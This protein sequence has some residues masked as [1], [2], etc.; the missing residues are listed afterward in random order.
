MLFPKKLTAFERDSLEAVP[1]RLPECDG[2]SSFIVGGETRPIDKSIAMVKL[3]NE[4]NMFLQRPPDAVVQ[5]VIECNNPDNRITKRVKAS[6]GRQPFPLR[7][8]HEKC[9]GV[10]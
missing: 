3:P 10:D 4:A 6:A 9:V 1:K 2:C 7:E 8:R 5:K